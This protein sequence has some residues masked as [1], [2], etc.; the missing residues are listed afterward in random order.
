MKFKSLINHHATA[1]VLASLAMSTTLTISPVELAYGQAADEPLV[2]PE[3]LPIGLQGAPVLP[4]FTAED[5][6]Q[7]ARDLEATSE[8]DP[9]DATG[10]TDNF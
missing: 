10:A 6:E 4:Q 1:C 7:L 5:V 9:E 3:N 2:A 8:R